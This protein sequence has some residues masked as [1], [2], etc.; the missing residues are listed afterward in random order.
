MYVS[1]F[2]FSLCF[3]LFVDLLKNTN[4]A[5]FAEVTMTNSFT[6]IINMSNLFFGSNAFEAISDEIP[7]EK[8]NSDVITGF[9]LALCTTK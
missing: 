4:K 8:T 9:K 3:H 1:V 6:L 7:V 5:A 2:H